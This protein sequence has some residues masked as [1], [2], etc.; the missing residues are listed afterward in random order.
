MG[1][2]GALSLWWR[3]IEQIT[4]GVQYRYSMNKLGTPDDYQNATIYTVKYNF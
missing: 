4:A 1:N 3:P 2:N